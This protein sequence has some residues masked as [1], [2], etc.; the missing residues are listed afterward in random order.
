MR[1]E[2]LLEVYF[3]HFNTLKWPFGSCSDGINI[4]IS[5]DATE[6]KLI[7]STNYILLV[8]KW[9]RIN[10]FYRIHI[11]LQFQKL[12][13][14]AMLETFENWLGLVNNCVYYAHQAG[15]TYQLLPYSVGFEAQ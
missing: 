2:Y 14:F 8:I 15:E 4:L 11:T 1:M 7:N 3:T 12:G 5:Q 9:R 13:Q 10:I 6:T